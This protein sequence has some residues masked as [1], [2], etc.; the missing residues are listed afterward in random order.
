LYV[1]VKNSNVTMGSV[2]LSKRML[3]EKV[4]LRTL[5]SIS[6]ILLETTCLPSS[7]QLPKVVVTQHDAGVAPG[8]E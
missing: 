7:L 2:S 1:L 5:Q 8:F 3:P 6:V 4:L